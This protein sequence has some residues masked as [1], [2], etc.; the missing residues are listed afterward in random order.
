MRELSEMVSLFDNVAGENWLIIP[1]YA[2]YAGGLVF[3]T[4]LGIYRLKLY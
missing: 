1:Y 3:F 2:H 4:E